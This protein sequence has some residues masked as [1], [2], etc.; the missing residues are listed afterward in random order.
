MTRS[1]R[2]A[3][4]AEH[5]RTAKKPVGYRNIRPDDESSPQP[6]FKFTAAQK[7]IQA[8][9][10]KLNVQIKLLEKALAEKAAL[11][12]ACEHEIFRDVAGHPYDW[13]FCC[14]CGDDMGYV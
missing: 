9:V 12:R 14:L 3:Q 7:G 10:K 5:A 13:R 8:E 1:T 6:V 2:W 4:V 11:Q